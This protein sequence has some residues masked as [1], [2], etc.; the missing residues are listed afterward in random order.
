MDVC[1]FGWRHTALPR[2]RYL[3][4]RQPTRWV[5]NSTCSTATEMCNM[6]N[7]LTMGASSLG[8]SLYYCMLKIKAS[9]VQISCLR[10][11]IQYAVITNTA[12][13]A[14]ARH[15]P[16]NLMLRNSLSHCRHAVTQSLARRTVAAAQYEP[17]PGRPAVRRA[18][19]RAR[20]PAHPLRTGLPPQLRIQAARPPR[21]DA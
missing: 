17:S 6:P 20:R 21:Q 3:S 2:P 12:A 19:D 9:I 7:M 8:T 10:S 11:L 5:P 4:R 14:C 18:P 15:V 13:E 1:Q 16:Q